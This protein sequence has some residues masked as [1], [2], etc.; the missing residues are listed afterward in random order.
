MRNLELPGRSVARALNGMAAT[1]H[2]LATLTAIN[3]LQEGGNA[4]DAA[5]A[6]CA[7]QGVVEPE[8]TGLGGDCFVL[9]APKGSSDIVAFNGS[10]R[11]PQAATAKWF[12]DQG[13]DKIER[14]TPH[15]V[16]VPGAVD[17]WAQLLRDHGT[18]S[19]GDL[20]QPAIRFA[21]EGYAITE[22]VATDWAG[23]V[24]TLSHDPAASGIFLPNGKPPALG[25]IHSQPALAASLEL[26]A[27][28]GRDAFYKGA[29]A[30]DLVA[31]LKELGGLHSLEDFAAAGGEYVDP[32]KTGYKGYDV[33][34]CPPN[35]QGVI[36]LLLLNILSGYDLPSLGAMSAERLHLEIEA[37]RLAY[38][39][40]NAY[41]ADPAQAEVPVE[42]LLS[43]DYAAELRAAID[44]KRA[45][46]PSAPAPVAAH[47]DTVYI[48][49]V[50]KDRNA[51]SFINSTFSSFGSG[52]C[53]PK[54]GIILQ[55]RGTSFS[56]DPE[57][58]N[59]IAPGKRPMHTIIPGMVAKGER[60]VMPFGVMGGQYQ[61][62]GHARFLTNL[63]DYGLDVQQSM[64][65]ARSFP[66]PGKTEVEAESGV[67]REVLAKLEE[68]GHRF[69]PPDK[70]IGGSQAIQIDWDQGTLAGGSD[71]RK[72]G[73]AL[74]Y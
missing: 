24:E 10:G 72:D 17:A 32:I 49:V 70:P 18:R 67:P 20:L 4:M 42:M 40:R 23:E 62:C 33:Y 25:S 53:G 48:C 63:F 11:A 50:D 69:C 68:M 41:V 64:D 66:P 39:T 19:L 47:A 71:P 73:C 59:C 1:S 3:V 56:V 9:F 35:G 14:Y 16:T 55:N 27:E 57:H 37:T 21:H 2:S 52:I 22:R 12:A 26:I 34:E 30:E 43:A 58:P 7:V 36:A 74:G 65:L 15:A 54:T 46:A 44:P 6:A 31:H 51:V 45:T 8:S 29:I 28:Q 61:A 13:I 5:V 38:Q 60:A